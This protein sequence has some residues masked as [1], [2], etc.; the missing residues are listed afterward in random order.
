[1]PTA[2]ADVR[3]RR[4]LARD[5]RRRRGAAPRGRRVDAD[6]RGRRGVRRVRRSLRARR[7]APARR[8]DGLGRLEARRSPVARGSSAGAAP[9]WPRTAST[10]CSRPAPSRSSCSTTSRPAAIDLE[11]VAE[12]VE[13]AAEVCRQAGCAILGGE[14]AELP[15]DLPRGASS[16]SAAT[17]RRPRRARR[18]DRRLRA[19]SAGDVVVGLRLGRHPRERL[20]ARPRASSATRPFDAELLLAADAAATSTRCARCAPAP[21][22]ARSPT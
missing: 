11:Q 5:G 1:M 15:G 6:R 3:R 17:C 12:L 21:T 20:L 16:T 18:A 22:S 7:A 14:T 13:G 10:T 8:V 4:S 9:T 2:R 19:S